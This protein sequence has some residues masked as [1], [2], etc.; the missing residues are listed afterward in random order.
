MRSAGIA[1]YV[2]D[3]G[4]PCPASV[5]PHAS[6]PAVRATWAPDRPSAQGSREPL[7]DR[8]PHQAVPARVELDLVD[9]VAVPVVRAQDRL[10]GVGLFA[11]LLGLDA[12]GP[13]PEPPDV[14]LRPAGLLPAQSLQ[15]G[16]VLGGVVRGEGRGLV[17]DVVGG[18]PFLRGCR[19]HESML[20]SCC[21][22][23]N[24][25]IREPPYST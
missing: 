2:I 8:D 7:G 5:C 16:A 24:D 17:G 4:Q 25:A 13:E 21:G 10:V 12:A 15:Q 22:C 14:L 6:P 3:V 18:G 1:A 9:A 20:R 11:P 19:D 23:S